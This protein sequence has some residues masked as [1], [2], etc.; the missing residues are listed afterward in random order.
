[1]KHKYAEP[2]FDNISL[3]LGVKFAPGVNFDPQGELLPLH[4]PPGLTL[5]TP[6]RGSSPQRDSFAYPKGR[7]ENSASVT[8]IQNVEIPDCRALQAL[9]E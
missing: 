6:T 8:G 7:F 9:P 5:L 4:S 3:P 2:I 1:M